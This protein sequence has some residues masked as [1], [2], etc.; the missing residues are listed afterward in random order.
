MRRVTCWCR[1]C[2][3]A[4]KRGGALYSV[5][6]FGGMGG[7]PVSSSPFVPESTERAAHIPVSPWG[8]PEHLVTTNCYSLLL[9]LSRCQAWILPFCTCCSYIFTDNISFGTK[10]K[11][12][13]RFYFAFAYCLHPVGSILQHFLRLHCA[14]FSRTHPKPFYHVYAWL[15]L[16]PA[17]MLFQSGVPSQC[18]KQSRPLILL[19]VTCLSSQPFLPQWTFWMDKA[20]PAMCS[21]DV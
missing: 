2:C 21:I 16:R 18:S 3:F 15:A 7:A 17:G 8:T 9:N 6:P 4:A 19:N 13:L 11:G 10:W 5:N 12:F 14:Y 20:S 1:S